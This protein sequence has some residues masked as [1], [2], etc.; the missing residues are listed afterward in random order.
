MS[1]NRETDFLWLYLAGSLTPV[2]LLPLFLSLSEL[3]L[4]NVDAYVSGNW[5]CHVTSSRG[6][7][8]I[9]MEIVVL[10][11]SAVYCSAERVIGNRGDFRWVNE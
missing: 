4:S 1:N 9:G 7:S 2:L 10:E 11:T 3:I 8:S 6:N 5:R